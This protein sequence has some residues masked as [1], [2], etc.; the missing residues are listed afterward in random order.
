MANNLEAPE[1]GGSAES[2]MAGR[3]A[4][5]P[6]DMVNTLRTNKTA[7]DELAAQA[8]AED[9]EARSETGGLHRTNSWL[10]KKHLE[11]ETT[12]ELLSRTLV[13]FLVSAV[14]NVGFFLLFGGP[15]IGFGAQLYQAL[16]EHYDKVDIAI[17]CGALTLLLLYIL[18][19]R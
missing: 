2:G 4:A 19:F 5:L 14:A 9:E 17:G 18:D 8:R 7:D 3:S 15:G 6:D 1:A 10:A 13:L 16:Y 12:K 11:P